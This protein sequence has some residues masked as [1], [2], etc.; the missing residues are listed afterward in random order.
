MADTKRQQS[1]EQKERYTPGYDSN[2][3]QRLQ[4]RTVAKNAA[5]FLS[6]LRPGMNLLDCG[7]GPGTITIGL[8]EAVAPGQVTGIDKEISHVES[9]RS[10]A[11]EKG[12]SNLCFE[13]GDVY[14]LSFPDASFDAVFSHFVLS[15]L[16]YPLRALKEMHRVLRP[17]GAIG[18][19]NIDHGGSLIAYSNPLVSKAHKL[20]L[21][22]LRHNGATI[23]VG[24][25]QR[26]LLHKAGFVRV[27]ASAAYESFGTPELVRERATFRAVQFEKSDVADQIV[28]LGWA[29]WSELEKISAAWRAWGESSDAFW[30]SAFCEAVGWK[31]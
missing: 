2:M 19:R 25:H 17:G 20:F 14:A 15:H 29:D 4:S 22:L 13:V 26:G 10:H 21:R 18:I 28:E 7:C 11:A 30:A 9:V 24:R 31:E 12:I 3:V 23:H 5:F 6:H 1:G 8:A 27:E 16:R